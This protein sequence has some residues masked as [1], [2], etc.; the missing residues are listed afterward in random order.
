MWFRWNRCGSDESYTSKIPILPV[1]F[2]LLLCT[3]FD[4]EHAATQR[5]SFFDSETN[6]WS[7]GWA[8]RWALLCSATA[9]RQFLFSPSLCHSHSLFLSLSLSLSLLLTHSITLSTFSSFSFSVIKD[10]CKYFDTDYVYIIVIYIHVN[11]M[12]II[13]PILVKYWSNIVQILVKYWSDTG[14]ALVKHVGRPPP[15]LCLAAGPLSALWPVNIT[16]QTRS[17]VAFIYM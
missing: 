16:G 4:S 13:S 15:T 3:G 7:K 1:D 11:Y 17:L 6:G 5:C 12:N 14:Q 8:K 9:S 10:F 2:H